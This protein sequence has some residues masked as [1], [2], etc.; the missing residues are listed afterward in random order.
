MSIFYSLLKTTNVCFLWL[1]ASM[2]DCS[3]KWL[4]DPPLPLSFPSPPLYQK[5]KYH[6]CFFTAPLRSFFLS[7]IHSMPPLMFFQT[8]PFM[9]FAS[10]HRV[11]MLPLLCSIPCITGTIDWPL[12]KQKSFILYLFTIWSMICCYCCIARGCLGAWMHSMWSWLYG[13]CIVMYQNTRCHCKKARTVCH[14]CPTAPRLVIKPLFV[15]KFLLLN[16]FWSHW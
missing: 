14:K 1:L 11:A 8:R 6:F 4:H 9:P 10:S 13:G 2:E 15:P 3:S 16:C 12:I 7:Q 5:A